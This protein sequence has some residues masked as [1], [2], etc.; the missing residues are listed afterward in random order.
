MLRTMADNRDYT[1]LFEIFGSGW[2]C[3]FLAGVSIAMIAS[4]AFR[5]F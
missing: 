5:Q 1:A 4:Q 3:G 2:L